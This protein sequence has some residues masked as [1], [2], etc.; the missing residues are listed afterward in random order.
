MTVASHMLYQPQK[1]RF[2]LYCIGAAIVAGL[3]SLALVSVAYFVATA[4]NGIVPSGPTYSM[5]WV[6]FFGLVV[7]APLVETAILVVVLRVLSKLP[8]QPLAV[9]A[10]A[11]VLWGGLHGLVFPLWFFGTVWSFFV[12]SCAYLSWQ[13]HSTKYGFWAAA[14]PHAL[15]NSAVFV[16]IASGV[17]A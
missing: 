9:A 12:F 8:L 3:G 4:S 1:K 17:G 11:A 6:D 15:L 10:L 5:G 2:W 13:T 14:L 16:P 7:F